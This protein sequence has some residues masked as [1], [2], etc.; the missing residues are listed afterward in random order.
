MNGIKR[1]AVLLLAIMLVL[2]AIPA[3]AAQPKK[4]TE[5]VAKPDKTEITLNVGEK[6]TFQV[7]RRFN[8]GKKD[9]VA[10]GKIPED[11]C[12]KKEALAGNRIRVTGLKEGTQ[13]LT[14][15]SV[16]DDT[17]VD[18]TVKPLVVT[19]HVVAPKVTLNETKI[20][21][22]KGETFQLIPTVT[23]ASGSQA[24]KY[25]SKKAAIARVGKKGLITAK[26]VGTTTITCR[27]AKNKKAFATCVVTVLPKDAPLPT[28]TPAPTMA[29]VPTETPA[30]TVTPAPTATPLPTTTPTTA[31]SPTPVG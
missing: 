23:I 2:T 7:V 30:P 3:I 6:Y 16:T 12:I 4:T 15:V 22:R 9:K 20:T 14:I 27:S 21:L 29:P 5:L 28:A 24:V 25:T 8:D 13:A 11:A 17:A 18:P 26:K 19:F 10:L 31:P 1:V